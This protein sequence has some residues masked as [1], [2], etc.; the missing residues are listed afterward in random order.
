M[1]V[2]VAELSIESLFPT[3]RETGDAMRT[4]LSGRA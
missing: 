3:N 1:D 2:T 4:L